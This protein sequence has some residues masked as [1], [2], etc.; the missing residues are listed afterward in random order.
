M[1]TNKTFTNIDT[2]I[3]SLLQE[4]TYPPNEGEETGEPVFKNVLVGFP[5]SEFRGFTF[6]LA[7][8]YVKGATYDDT[9]GINNRPKYINSVI[10]VV[11]TGDNRTRYEKLREIMDLIQYKFEYDKNWIKLNNT[12]RRVFVTDS[13]LAI[14]QTNNDLASVAIFTLR[15]HVFKVNNGG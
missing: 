7:I 14:M 5:E 4:L 10:G 11:V 12:V 9:F 8:C 6:P 2:Q 13:A 3:E 1:T 15:H